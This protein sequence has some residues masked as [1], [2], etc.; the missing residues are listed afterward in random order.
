MPT[1]T[2][3]N[4]GLS[5]SANPKLTPQCAP[6][7]GP[8]LYIIDIEILVVEPANQDLQFK[9]IEHHQP[10]Q[11]NDIVAPLE[12]CRTLALKLDFQLVVQHQIDVVD[13]VLRHH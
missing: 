1:R 9:L 7:N 2:S 6:I 12:E 13:P 8:L 4:L 10:L 3:T 11:L 5:Y